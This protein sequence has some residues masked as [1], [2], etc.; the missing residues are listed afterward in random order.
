MASTPESVMLAIQNDGTVK[1]GLLPI[2]RQDSFYERAAIVGYLKN[3]SR[4]AC[5]PDGELF[6][7]RG[8]DLYRGPIPGNN[9]DWFSV[10]RRVGKSVWSTFK[11]IF[12]HPNG[13]LYGTTS[14]GHFYKGPKP[15]NENV[16]WPYK[17]A[18]LIGEKHWNQF[19]ALFFDPKG[20]LYAVTN[21]KFVKADPPSAPMDWLKSSTVVG[22][23]DWFRMTHFMAFSSDGKLCCVAKDDG[24]LYRGSIPEDGRYKDNADKLGSR[25]N[26]FP[27]LS[28]TVD[29]TI[30]NIISFSFLP[31]KGERV[32]ETPEFIQEEI[33]DNRKSS[34]VLKHNFTVDKTIKQSS[35]FTHEHGFTVL[36]G[37]ELEFKAGI[38]CI[39]ETGAKIKLDLSTTHK[40]SFTETNETSHSFSSTTAVELQPG[41]AIRMV[42]SVVKAKIN[43]PYR[44]R[45]RTVCGFEAE[46][47]G[48]WN[49]V[50]HYNMMVTQEDYNK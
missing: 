4:I 32:S 14:D 29:K 24:T 20:V 7:V 44:A 26:M 36:I 10:A 9:V 11:I 49:G 30:H 50:S 13:D 19:D 37:G 42:A 47:E 18:T 33:A 31:E 28:F 45:V 16:S 25:Y 5:S 22:G 15:D 41:K 2:N 40:W 39:A 17:Q 35:T 8:T 38:P 21:D 1:I 48:M 6:C 34:S 23:C 3:V 12:F 43:V 27:F 46:I